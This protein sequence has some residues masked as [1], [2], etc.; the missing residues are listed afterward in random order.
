MK[1]YAVYSDGLED[2]RRVRHVHAVRS[3][4]QEASDF[5]KESAGLYGAL[6]IKAFDD[7]KQAEAFEID[8]NSAQASADDEWRLREEAWSKADFEQDT[9]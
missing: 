4:L 7:E 3:T 6:A 2:G 9:R 8:P 1:V 5:A